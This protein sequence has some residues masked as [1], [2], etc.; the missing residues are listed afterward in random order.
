MKGSN[1]PAK[2]AM[3][4]LS[5]DDVSMTD[6]VHE[7]ESEP[8]FEAIGSPH[9]RRSCWQVVMEASEWD[10]SLGSLAG[11]YILQDI[12]E[13]VTTLVE[14]G[15]I[16]TVLGTTEANVYVMVDFLLE[17]TGVLQYGF[18]EGNVMYKI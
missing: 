16:S 9:E 17:L 15:V 14:L 3:S 2:S 6:G 5:V 4:K 13:A 1:S 12:S 7:K 8:K 10:S 18:Q 11:L